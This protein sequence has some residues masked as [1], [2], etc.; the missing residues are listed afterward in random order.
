MNENL[1][2]ILKQKAKEQLKF[3][4]VAELPEVVKARIV[5]WEF[6]EDKR[7]NECLLCI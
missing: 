6:K 3:L 1:E 2:S 4:S 7:G 5:K